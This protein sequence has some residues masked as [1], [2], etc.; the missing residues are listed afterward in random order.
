MSD[1]VFSE[2]E[3]ATRL[4]N[5][6]LSTRFC[7]KKSLGVGGMGEVYLAEDSALRRLVA[8]KTVRPDLARDPEI[9]RRIERECLLHAKVG[10]HPHIVTLY[11]KLEDSGHI[12]LVMEFVPGES[13]QQLL[14]RLGKEGTVLPVEDAI[15]IAIQVLDALSR[16]HAHG[17]V[18][19][20]IKPSNIL[21]ARDDG[22]GLCAKLMDFGIARAQDDEMM[23]RL[24]QEAGSGPGTPLYMA[25]EQI[26]P[27]TFGDVTP[28]TDVYAMGIM[29]YQLT[30]GE[31]P[32]SGTLTQIFSG[33]LHGTPPSLRDRARGRVPDSL[34]E[35][36]QCALA[37]QPGQRFPT[38]KAFRDE[39]ARARDGAPSTLSSGGAHTLPAGD[40]NRTMVG[41]HTELN[42][43]GPGSTLPAGAAT[44]AAAAARRRGAPVGLIA[45]AAVLLLAGLGAAAY[46][47]LGRGGDDTPPADAS[48]AIAESETPASTPAPATPPTAAV[49]VPPSAPAGGMPAPD[50]PMPAVAVDAP[51]GPLP[52]P[53]PAA[54][55]IPPATTAPADSG[56]SATEALLQRLGERQAED[57]PAADPEPPAAVPASVTPSAPAPKVDVPKFREDP[58][59][60]AASKPA[61]PKPKPAAPKAEPAAPKPAP[62]EPAPAD[63]GGGWSVKGRSSHKVD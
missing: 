14:E 21:L 31:P 54:A 46:F 43:G 10:A 60:P 22:G 23:S 36:V 15:T 18:H 2:S 34:V 52:A 24:T 58:P 63:D 28:A 53:A 25:P 57:P 7:L 50:A 11:D 47:A 38:A 19:R 39:L 55:D 48:P 40:P 4:S 45:G 49:E 8:I 61:A 13:L 29:L 42:V 33:H 17:I 44:A 20:D 59:K 5:H 56:G 32:F 9:R 12:N 41:G 35:V 16:I 37:K 62:A 27:Q 1:S 3:V 26:D 51:A 30:S 6:R